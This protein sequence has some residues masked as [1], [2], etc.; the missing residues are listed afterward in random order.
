MVFLLALQLC[1]AEEP[2]QATAPAVASGVLLLRNGQVI[3]GHIERNGDYYRVTGPDQE[4]QIHSASVDCIC[5]DLRDGYQRKK[6]AIQPTDIQQHLQL[7]LWC[8]RHG[9]FDCANE[10]LDAAEAIDREHPMIVVLRR[11]LKVESQPKPELAH[12]AKKT[13]RPPGDDE[14]DHMV[15]GMPQGTV[16]LF[17]QIVQPIL[18][19]HYPGARGYDLPDNKRLLLMRAP[20]G[21]FPG[22]RITQRNLYAVLQCL[23]LEQSG[24]KPDGQGFPPTAATSNFP[25]GYSTQYLK[26]AQWV[27][28]VA[29]KP[30]PAEEGG[31][32][33]N[34]SFA[35][36]ATGDAPPA[37]N[38]PHIPYMQA[39]FFRITTST[40]RSRMLKTPLRAIR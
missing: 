12:P 6:A 26:L 24:R 37:V 9:L 36:L 34:A 40:R 4:I 29:Q 11:R 31:G 7:L 33:E 27:Y 21:E 22:R 16:E 17:V 5:R 2:P 8:E 18:L 1:A 30:M 13:E 38:R 15:R 20:L 10:Q 14:L 23:D 19:N 28:L 25:A 3:E 39:I 35:D 32:A